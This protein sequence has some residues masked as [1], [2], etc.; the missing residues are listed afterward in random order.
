MVAGAAR[1]DQHEAGL[2]GGDALGGRVELITDGQDLGKHGGLLGDLG[3][4]QCA[5]HG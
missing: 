3:R 4:H 5:G 1:R 2:G